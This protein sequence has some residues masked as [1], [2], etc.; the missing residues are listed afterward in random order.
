MPVDKH[1]D[2]E[3]VLLNENE[4]LRRR[5]KELEE[6]LKTVPVTGGYTVPMETGQWYVEDEPKP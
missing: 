3:Y 1:S 6:R 5:V 2:L 4:C